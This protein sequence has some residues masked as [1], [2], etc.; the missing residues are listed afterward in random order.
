MV[1]G[2]PLKPPSLLL[3]MAARHYLNGGATKGL[4]FINQRPVPGGA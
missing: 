3:G 2:N 1:N 4:K